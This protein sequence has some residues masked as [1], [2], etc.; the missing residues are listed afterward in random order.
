[1]EEGLCCSVRRDTNG[2]E[3]MLMLCLYAFSTELIHSISWK[4]KLIQFKSLT[5]KKITL[6][7]EIRLMGKVQRK[8]I[9]QYM[10]VYIY[11]HNVSREWWSAEV[12][13]EAGPDFFLTQTVDS[14]SQSV[15]STVIRWLQSRRYGCNTTKPERDGWFPPKNVLGEETKSRQMK[16]ARCP[17]IKRH[18]RTETQV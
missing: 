12:R 6:Q 5:S 16:H 17:I 9:I 10:Y 18:K 2:L 13:R 7:T 8:S 11:I 3:L 15:T 14:C 4:W 1:M